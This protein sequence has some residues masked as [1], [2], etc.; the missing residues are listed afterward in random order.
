MNAVWVGTETERVLGLYSLPFKMEKEFFKEAT[1]PHLL[2][3]THF[4]AFSTSARKG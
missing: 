4:S 1:A 3:Y 2:V